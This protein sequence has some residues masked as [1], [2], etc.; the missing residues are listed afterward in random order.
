MSAANANITAND[1]TM[2]PELAV[3]LQQ[4]DVRYDLN[5]TVRF[6]ATSSRG[7]G[8]AAAVAFLNWL[9]PYAASIKASD[10]HFRDQE[11]GCQV[12]IRHRD[13]RLS[14]AWLLSRY[15]A[16]TVDEKIRAKCKISTNEREMPQGGSFWMLSEDESLMVDVRVSILPT[17]F[18]QN[19]VCRLLNQAQSG[20]GMDAVY[21]PADLRAVLH[22]VLAAPQ[23]MVLVSGPTGSGKSFTLNC[24]L[25]HVN[26][27]DKHICTAE[28]PVEYPIKGA[29]Q[30]NI[31]PHHRPFARVLREFLRQDPDII[32]VGEI[33]DLETAQTAMTA[34]NT[35]HL[36]FS[37]IHANSAALSVTR[38]L[39]MGVERYA[40]AD[41]LLAF[42]AQR[43]LNQ[44]CPHCRVVI[45]PTAPAPTRFVQAAYYR[46]DP[47]GCQH[48]NEGH[49][50]R[51]PVMEFALN[52]PA[53]RLAILNNDAEG[54]QQALLAQPTYRTLTEA[55]LDMAHLGLVDYDDACTIAQMDFAAAGSTVDLSDSGLSEDS[56]SAASVPE[57]EAA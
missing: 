5:Q 50:G 12:R 10:V 7:G 48:C 55:A 56:L 17:R 29:N 9:F 4:A 15:A 39:G 6:I 44:L 53:V 2:P 41:A 36:L 42:F 34:A 23:G 35:G 25:N 30:V 47:A 38:L 19:I 45:T 21:M 51:I 28:D 49:I 37:T 33:R 32:L 27:D 3:L 52:T 20:M 26:R 13:M 24:C 54:L 14:D 31:H 43:L 40:L 8:D 18:G 22:Q 16:Q 57:S 11:N 46:R 1:G